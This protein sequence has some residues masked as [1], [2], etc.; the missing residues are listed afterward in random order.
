MF[1]ADEF[2][3]ALHQAGVTHVVGLPDSTLGE[4]FPAIDQSPQLTLVS[5]CR[6][7]E[8]WAVAAG[9][10]V[11]GAAPVVL[12]QCTGLFESGDSLRNAIHDYGLPLFGIIGYR[13]YLN[14]SVLPGDTA[15]LFTEPILKA[16]QLDTILIDTPDKKPLLIEHYH[17]CRDQQ[18][19][20]IALI[21]E[22]RV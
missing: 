16:W 21:A 18:R 12:I 10:H 11:G 5:V 2:V 20:G 3:A 8:A 13:S 7:G 1:T 14:Q 9:L 15:R 17:T 22:G 4:W 19:P 6:E